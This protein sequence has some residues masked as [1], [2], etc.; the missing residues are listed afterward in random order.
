MSY[1]FRGVSL[2]DELKASIDAYVETGRPTGGFLEAVIDNDLMQAFGRADDSSIAALPAII[3]YLY[4]E[5][6]SRCWGRKG[7]FANWVMYKK[8]ERETHG[9]EA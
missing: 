6:D 2:P 8:E 1:V 4:N 5:V 7:A 9:N 3:G